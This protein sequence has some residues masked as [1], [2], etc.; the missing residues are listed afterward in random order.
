MKFLRSFFLL[1]FLIFVTAST[2]PCNIPVFRYALELW[3]AD[4]LDLIVLHEGEFNDSQNE[5]MEWIRDW[6]TDPEF[7]ANLHF[8]E[9]NVTEDDSPSREDFEI[10]DANLPL[11]MLHHPGAPRYEG[12]FWKGELSMENIQQ[13]LD[14][15][16]RREVAKLLLQGKTAVWVFMESGD[17]EKDE[18]AYETLQNELKI[19]EESLRLPQQNEEEYTPDGK[20][21]EL[22]NDI[23]VKIDFTILRLPHSKEEEA[24]FAHSL[25]KTEVDL[26]DYVDEPM[27]FPIYGRGRALYALIGKGIN[28][29]TIRSACEF[30]TGPCTCQVKNLNPGVDL[31]MAVNWDEA[32]KGN[33]VSDEE[34]AKVLAIPALSQA[35]T[36]QTQAATQTTVLGTSGGSGF[37]PLYRNILIAGLLLI[38]INAFFVFRFVRQRRSN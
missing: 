12:G 7:N 17:P 37:P 32:L 5:A 22:E 19:L 30:V 34:L 35:N 25:I 18:Q 9:F 31:L 11:M 1:T 29:D 26:V 23:P 21:I 10:G 3:R 2:W 16:L 27:A 14:S 13:L 24:F 4:Q 28:E 8:H 36:Q 33:R 38:A 20:V 6:K 15:P